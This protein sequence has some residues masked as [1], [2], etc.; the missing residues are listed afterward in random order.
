MSNLTTFFSHGSC[1]WCCIQKVITKPK[2]VFISPIYL[3]GVLLTVVKAQSLYPKKKKKIFFLHVDVHLIQHHLLKRLS[4]SLYYLC[5]FVTD[6]LTLFIW[7]H[8]WTLHYSSL[9]YLALLLTILQSLDYCSLVVDVE[10][11]QCQSSLFFN[12]MLVYLWSFVLV[13]TLEI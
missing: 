10:V 1:L 11:R 12:I 2:V 13:Q 4:A 3:L 5:S 8:F 6:Q 7:V 9:K